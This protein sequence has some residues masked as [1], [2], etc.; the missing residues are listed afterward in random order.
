M[1]T[2]EDYAP[3]ETVHIVGTGFL[4]GEPVDLS[5]AIEGDDG[6]W[7]PDVDWTIEFTDASG[8]LEATYIIRAHL[9]DGTTR[10][11]HISVKR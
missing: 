5:I 1:L 7:T 9:G 8:T 4:P 10:D 11:V 6:T 3:G 2:K